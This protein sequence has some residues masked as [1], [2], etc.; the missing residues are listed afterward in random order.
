ML[1]NYL[2]IAFRTLFKGHWY[3][4]ANLLSLSV[5]L[6]ST[7]LIGLYI[8]QELS[9]DRQ[10]AQRQQVYRLVAERN[11]TNGEQ[12]L[13][14]TS[15]V[16][17]AA[18]VQEEI[19]GVRKTAR[20]YSPQW[21]SQKTLV[22]HGADRYYES[23]VVY[24][25]STFFEVLDGYTFA[26]GDPRTALSRPASVVL[27]QSAARKYFG[28]KDPIG[29]QLTLDQKYKVEVTGVLNGEQSPSHLNADFIVSFDLVKTEYGNLLSLWGWD[30]VYTYVVLEPGSRHA[31]VENQLAPLLARHLP[32]FREERG[33][34]YEFDLQPLTDIHLHSDRQWEIQPNGKA[35]YIQVVGVMA[36]LI[37]LVSCTNSINLQLTRLSARLVEMSVRKV[38]GAGSR[39]VPV[40]LVTE[41]G[42][43][44][45][46]ALLLAGLMGWLVWPFFENLTG[47]Q[48]TFQ[49]LARTP[50]PWLVGG[51][52]LFITVLVGL[53]PAQFIVRMNPAQALKSKMAPSLSLSWFRKGMLL[54]QFSV[55]VFL[56]IASIVLYRQLHYWNNQP[57]G[58]DKE[59]VIMVRG[60]GSTEAF[61]ALKEA[62]KG[63]TGV[64]HVAAVSG[65]PGSNIEKMRVIWEGREEPEPVDMLWV[66]ED[67]VPTLDIKL[68]AG[69]NFSDQ[70]GTD[71]L[72]AFLI[73][74]S[75]AR[76][77][78]WQQSLGKEVRWGGK[79]GLEG[80]VVG[81]IRDIH[82]ASLHKPVEPLVLFVRPSGYTMLAVRSSGEVK[83]VLAALEKIWKNTLPASPFEYDLLDQHLARQYDRESLFGQVI[84][85]F[86]F[87]AI[88]IACL[89]LFSLTALAV[90]QRT[91]EIAV[92]KVLGAGIGQ[93]VSL[94]SRDF[95][96]LIL[97]AILLASPLAWWLLSR[98]LERFAYHTTILWWTYPLAGTLAVGIALITVSFQSIKAALMNPVKSLRSE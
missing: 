49:N 23:A 56:L 69:R 10:H 11:Y 9:Y 60:Y 20:V 40:Q 82:H 45:G 4:F 65:L 96:W 33:Y 44:T 95:F 8:H 89:G 55:S 46:L 1:K 21:I 91:K 48:Y 87:L 62:F 71:S 50:Y 77:L 16:P 52:V 61:P 14:A 58:F 34:A 74:E 66:D 22:A 93:I 70:F 13:Y 80:R 67:F 78:G 42:L 98:W 43:L 54:G 83:P 72:A 35:L 31:D 32:G 84:V 75:A 47:Q 57:L 51:C 38:L 85:A 3:S 79:S 15:P 18:L 36:L 25:D 39:Q 2:I 90:E 29:Q 12:K 94:L 5:G 68:A 81:V 24:A 37:L 6:V 59:S 88:F 63:V 73:N 19:P 64:S 76:S 30:M 27:T 53:L 41:A 92:R 97:L 86:T 7:A 17:M 26:A 28:G